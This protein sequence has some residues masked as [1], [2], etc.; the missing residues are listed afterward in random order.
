V[1]AAT[2]RSGR[3]PRALATV[4][5]LVLAAAL[6]GCGGSGG[7]ASTTASTKATVKP[8]RFG[9][10]SFGDSVTNPALN[11]STN[12]QLLSISYA[13]LLYQKPNGAIGPALATSWRY[14]GN[15]HKVFELALRHNAR[16]SDGT[17]V[18]AAAVLKWLD[19]YLASKNSQSGLLGSKPTFQATDKWTVR[20]TMKQ[21]NPDVP[22]LLTQ[23]GVAWGF[24][25]S[26]KAVANPNLFKK[27]SYGA[28]PYKLDYA[29]SVPGDHYVFVPNPYYYDKPAITFKQVFVKA[30]A[31]SSS[32]L[33]ALG[34]GQLD[35]VSSVDATTASAAASAGLQV[36]TAPYAVTFAQL[37]PKGNKALADVRV[38]RAMNYALDREAIAKALY[39]KYGTPTSEAI[40]VND[41]DPGLQD[42]YAY[43]PAKAKSLLAAAGYSKG[44]AFSLDEVGPQQEKIAGLIAH[45]LDAVGIKTKVVKFTTSSAYFDA[46]F[47]FND[48]AWLLGAG[49]GSSTPNAYGPFVGPESVFKPGEPVDP[50]FDRLY[51]KGLA[52]SDPTADWKQMWARVTKNAWF[53]PTAAAPFLVFAKKSVSGI[54]MSQNRP[55]AYPV[56]WFFAE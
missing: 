36:R 30:F 1:T 27:A 10:S 18:D 4:A 39:G 44:F 51:D 53:L 50:E 17:R 31:D 37:N 19:Y 49:T 29:R 25:A 42:Y 20:I 3:R 22:G 38:R 32:M 5:A 54:E 48:D 47:K 15:E 35:A 46:I 52:A 14:I 33:Q 43:D 55:T 12:G 2:I 26:P 7:S 28:G 40:I 45:Y 16:F 56:E 34:A 21:A 11:N 24:V 13:P 9:V 41:A 8:L 23:D 6:A